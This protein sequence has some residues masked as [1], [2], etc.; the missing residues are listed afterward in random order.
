MSP[1]TYFRNSYRHRTQVWPLQ[2]TQRPQTPA[3]LT[4]GIVWRRVAIG[5]PG[6]H[7]EAWC[8]SEYQAGLGYDRKVAEA[9]SFGTPGYAND[10]IVGQSPVESLQQLAETP[11]FSEIM[12]TS[13]GGTP[14]FT[15]VDRNL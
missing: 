4:Q 3:S 2:N 15:T 1:G 9:S 5:K 12:F 14:F 8:T 6:Y 13:R 7:A 11:T 10:A